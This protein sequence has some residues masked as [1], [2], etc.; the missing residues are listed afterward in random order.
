MADLLLKNHA[1]PD[2]RFDTSWN[3]QPEKNSTALLL[4]VRNNKTDIIESLL[5]HKAD[6]NLKSDAGISPLLA[7]VYTN[8]TERK[9]MVSLL[10]DHGAEVDAK[11]S[12]GATTLILAAG[13]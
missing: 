5:E 13:L 11:D 1:D 4:A 6:P 7:A 12:L 2:L 8:P 3:N 9:R 10:L